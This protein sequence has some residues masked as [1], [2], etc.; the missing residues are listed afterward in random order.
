MKGIKISDATAKELSKGGEGLTPDQS[1]QV[2]RLRGKQNGAEV[3]DSH[4]KAG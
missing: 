1:I 3:H 2:R 4:F